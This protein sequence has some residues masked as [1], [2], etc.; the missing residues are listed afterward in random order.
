METDAGRMASGAN[1]GTCH[2]PRLRCG[3]KCNEKRAPLGC[4]E[5]SP[6]LAEIVCK[7]MKIVELRALPQ[8]PQGGVVT[9]RWG[10]PCSSVAAGLI[11]RV[12]RLRTQAT[13][14]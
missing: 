8:G 7:G 12:L 11:A 14:E 5:W 10:A 1:V 13:S 2:A 4:P 3:S 9:R 6:R